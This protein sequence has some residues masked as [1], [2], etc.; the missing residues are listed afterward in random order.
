MIKNNYGGEERFWAALAHISLVL[1]LQVP[2]GIGL[3]APISIVYSKRKVSRWV[4]FQS[5]QA[6]AAH[7]LTWLF[8]IVYLVAKTNMEEPNSVVVNILAGLPLVGIIYALLGTLATA[9][10]RNFR[11][12]FIGYFIERKLGITEEN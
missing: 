3:L 2:W 8:A 7:S 9:M 10:S 6:L 5:L 12:P 4:A 1:V 11:Y